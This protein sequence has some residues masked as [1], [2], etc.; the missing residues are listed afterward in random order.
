M[1]L[2]WQLLLL[3]VYIIAANTKATNGQPTNTPSGLSSLT[4]EETTTQMDDEFVP[5]TKPKAERRR[6]GQPDKRSDENFVVVIVLT[7]MAFV[8]IVGGVFYICYAESKKQKRKKL[9][10]TRSTSSISF[11]DIDKSVN[12]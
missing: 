9:A 6:S 10:P 11:A 7:V 8:S 12:Y 4:T 2:K 3:S 1:I 5:F